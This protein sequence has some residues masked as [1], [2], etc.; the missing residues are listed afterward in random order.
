MVAGEHANF[1]V[2]RSRRGWKLSGVCVGPIES[3]RTVR[4]AG[5]A[6]GVVGFRGEH[7]TYGKGRAFEVVRRSASSVEQIEADVIAC[8]VNARF[9]IARPTA[10]R[11]RGPR[12]V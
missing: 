12:W 2:N 8:H 7:M 4:R 11:A 1:A 3:L 10:A 9:D 5:S 6:L